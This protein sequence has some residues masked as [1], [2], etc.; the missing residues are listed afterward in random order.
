M[1]NSRKLDAV[2]LLRNL[3]HFSGRIEVLTI[4]DFVIDLQKAIILID[5][6]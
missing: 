6:I 1:K 2:K 5:S 3:N 4:A